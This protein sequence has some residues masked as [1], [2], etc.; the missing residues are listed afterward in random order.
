MEDLNER[1]QRLRQQLNPLPS[2]NALAAWGRFQ[3]P[4]DYAGSAPPKDARGLLATQRL[5]A[6]EISG[7]GRCQF[8]AFSRAAFST[9]EHADELRALAVAFLRPRQAEYDDAMQAYYKG[10]CKAK[11]SA[12][13][14]SQK[15]KAADYS[16]FLDAIA[17]GEEWGNDV[18]LEALGVLMHVEVRLLQNLPCPSAWASPRLLPLRID[19]RDRVGTVQAVIYLFLERKH[20]STL[21]SYAPAV[22]TNGRSGSPM[23]SQSGTVVTDREHDITYDYNNPI[24]VGGEELTGGELRS[25]VSVGDGTRLKMEPSVNGE[26]WVIFREHTGSGMREE[27]RRLD[28]STVPP[29]P[30]RSAAGVEASSTPADA[31][32]VTAELNSKGWRAAPDVVQELF[33]LV[34]NYVSHLELCRDD[35]DTSALGTLGSAV[36]GYLKEL[37]R[38]KRQLYF[39]ASASSQPVQTVQF[40]GS[41]GA[42]K[43][44][45][46]NWAIKHCLREGFDQPAGLELVDEVFRDQERVVMPAAAKE[47]EAATLAKLLDDKDVKF[48]FNV[49]K[50]DI[51]CTGSGAGAMTALVSHIF[52]DPE[53]PDLQLVL[54]YRSKA[55]VDEVLQSVAHAVE[56]GLD[57]SECDERALYFALALLGLDINKGGASNRNGDG[58]DSESSDSD[59]EK[60]V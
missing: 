5:R 36:L 15:I 6:G 24:M 23:P 28:R 44:T 13:V 17:A 8:S 35:T 45:L 60:E 25:G 57:E 32:S 3:R 29:A 53:A 52:L 2:E 4:A 38:L 51:L 55:E 20:Y 22:A 30:V 18:T 48:C 16:G 1:A 21:E 27:V 59:E 58:S 14:K 56:V 19:P 43:S 11:L 9:V 31:A 40:V 39:T 41:A 12:L 10:E 34:S 42:G 26:E 47:E 46:V 49:T 50:E 7:D 33:Q 54:T 37:Q